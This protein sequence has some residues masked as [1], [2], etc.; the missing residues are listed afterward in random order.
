MS[1][2]QKLR[3]NSGKVKIRKILVKLLQDVLYF[4]LKFSYG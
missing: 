4:Y 1:A 3:K 2:E